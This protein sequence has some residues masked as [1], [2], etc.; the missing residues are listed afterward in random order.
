MEIFRQLNFINQ[1]IFYHKRRNNSRAIIL[2]P[3]PH[4]PPPDASLVHGGAGGYQPL[5]ERETVNAKGRVPSAL[6]S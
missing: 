5:Q 6:L 1:M 3:S 2:S 4:V